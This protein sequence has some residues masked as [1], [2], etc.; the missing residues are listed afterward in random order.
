MS[1]R[2]PRWPL[3]AAKRIFR[4]AYG[5]SW[6][7]EARV[8]GSIPVFG[9]NG[10]IGVHNLPNTEAP[11]IIVGRKGS[12]GRLQYVGDRVFSIDTTYFVDGRFTRVDL[13][14]LFYAL[15]T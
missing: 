11:V 3:V 10:P 2:R 9:S 13:K 5:D 12:C 7:D 8:S 14:W 6:S 15:T 4:L 1:D